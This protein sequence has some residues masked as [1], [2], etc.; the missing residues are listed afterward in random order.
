MLGTYKN[1]DRRIEEPSLEPV[2]VLMLTLDAQ[3]FLEKCLDSVYR[4]VPVNRLLIMDGGSKDQTIE[5][6]KKYP[7]VEINIR[8]D[9]KTTAKCFEVLFSLAK[10]PWIVF[11]DADM[12]F[13]QGWYDQMLM[14]KGDIDF[15]EARR[16]Q[17]FEFYR[18]C[19]GSTDMNKRS[20]GVGQLA[21]LECF[22]DFHVEDD[23]MWGATDLFLKQVAEKNGYKFGKIPEPFH[24]HH[25]TENWRFNSDSQK[26]GRRL[27]FKDP[28]WDI[29]NKAN[30]E[31][32]WDNYRKAIV[33]YLEPA[34]I[35]PNEWDANIRELRQLDLEWV[36]N[37]STTWYNILAPLKKPRVI[38]TK[39]YWIVAKRLV[40][41]PF[42][43]PAILKLARNYLLS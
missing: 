33:K 28:Q 23:Y 39:R 7:R 18:E 41:L 6:L 19:P 38:I 21:K 34:A 31:K 24:Y 9:I 26:G 3:T 25:T 11:V 5:I 13:C 8:P 27:T 35:F 10:T 14:N 36:K 2:D 20:Y 40:S 4:E 22:K 43:L 29:L 12:E 16:V 15:C 37:T 17:H 32:A 30:W 1:I 42:K